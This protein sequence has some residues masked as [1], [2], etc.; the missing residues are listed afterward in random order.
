MT[1]ELRAKYP[2]TL[3]EARFMER[4]TLKHTTLEIGPVLG[5]QLSEVESMVQL[6]LGSMESNLE[7]ANGDD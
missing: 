1:I 3:G 6:C 7:E 4:E 2:L 5:T